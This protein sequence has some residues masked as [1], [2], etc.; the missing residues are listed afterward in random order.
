M[1]KV[2]KHLLR[3]RIWIKSIIS[4][5]LAVVKSEIKDKTVIKC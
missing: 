2:V 3:I 1:V 5:G 4:L